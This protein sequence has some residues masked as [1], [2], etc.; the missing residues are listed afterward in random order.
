MDD[1]ETYLASVRK[2]PAYASAGVDLIDRALGSLEGAASPTAALAK[3][4]KV[5]ALDL[6]HPMWT[7]YE[8]EDMNDSVAYHGN[9]IEMVAKEVKSKSLSE[10][11]NRYYISLGFVLVLVSSLDRC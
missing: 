6:G 8:I 7:E 9:D 11:V 4:K 3:I 10:I 5:K 1:V 2:L